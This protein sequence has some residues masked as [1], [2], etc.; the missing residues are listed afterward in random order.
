MSR[1]RPW[2]AHATS[3]VRFAAALLAAAPSPVGA[4]D[5]SESWH[6]SFTPYLWAA[7]TKGRSGVK[8]FVGDV[9]LSAGDVLKSVDIAFMGTLEARRGRWFGSLDAFYVGLSDDR[10]IESTSLATQFKIK[11]ELDQTMLAPEAGYRV[12]AWPTGSVQ[13]LAG[14][15]YWHVTGKITVTPSGAAARSSSQSTDWVDGIVGARVRATPWGP[16]WRL[17]GRGDLGAGGSDFTWQALGGA[18]YDLSRCCA[19]IGVYRH[20]DVDYETSSF[21]NDVYMTGPALGVVI[22]F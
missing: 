7:N 22:R 13:A 12:A 9:D 4:Q 21:T 6:W 15:R 2:G 20:L 1:T 16:R 8:G 18:A 5:G 14:L 10:T 17:Y 19:I 3:L 11:I